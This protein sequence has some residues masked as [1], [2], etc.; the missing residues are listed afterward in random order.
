M[1]SVVFF[2]SKSYHNI[3]LLFVDISLVLLIGSPVHV[4]DKAK[5][6]FVMLNKTSE[7]YDAIRQW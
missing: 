3:I 5:N 6:Y 4:V 2:F 1:V 7:I